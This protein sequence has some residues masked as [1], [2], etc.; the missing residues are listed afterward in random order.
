[1]APVFGRRAVCSASC[2]CLFSLSCKTDL[3]FL[4]IYSENHQGLARTVCI[5]P[6]FEYGVDIKNYSKPVYGWKTWIRQIVE[7][8]GCRWQTLRV[9][10]PASIIIK[11]VHFLVKQAEEGSNRQAT[12]SQPEHCR[13]GQSF[14]QHYPQRSAISQKYRHRDSPYTISGVVMGTTH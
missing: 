11:I 7:G 14:S 3:R 4:D 1:M 10:K 8:K 13:Q 5:M 12:I 2:S 9:T 6:G